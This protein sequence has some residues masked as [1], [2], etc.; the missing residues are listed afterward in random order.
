MQ[1]IDVIILALYMIGLIVIGII[2]K[3]RIEH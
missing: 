2:A 1:A 3:G